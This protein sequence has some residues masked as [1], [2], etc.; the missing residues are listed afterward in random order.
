[1]RLDTPCSLD[2]FRTPKLAQ[3]DLWRTIFVPGHCWPVRSRESPSHID[4]IVSQINFISPASTREASKRGISF[5]T[6]FEIEFIL[7]KST[8]PEAEA[9]SIHDWSTTAS[10]YAGSAGATVLE[11]IADALQAG[12]VELQMY[13]AE[14]APGQYEVVTGPLSPLQAA[15]A[16][17]YSR[18]VIYNIAN[19][20]HLRATFAPRVFGHSCP[21]S[22]PTQPSSRLLTNRG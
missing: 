13:H 14:A 2:G 1:M 22:S 20:H 11:E 9:I 4:R 6:G 12:G 15:D 21:S 17:V 3:N 10:I 5:L 19:R 7:L 16:L 18:E 8:L